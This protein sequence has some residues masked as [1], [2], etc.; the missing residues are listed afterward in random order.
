MKTGGSDL[1]ELRERLRS[2][3]ERDSALA[4]DIERIGARIGIGMPLW[5]RALSGSRVLAITLGRHIWISEGVPPEA[6]AR[7]VRHELA[8]VRQM[9]REGLVPF[10]HEYLREYL[11]GR[12]EGLDPEEAYRAIPF[13][14]EAR[15]AES[16]RSGGG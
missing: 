8:H 7:L 12:T 15:E 16:G 1:R 6:L 14:R 10:L 5:L 4:D 2:A 9:R 11:I 13:E 3:L